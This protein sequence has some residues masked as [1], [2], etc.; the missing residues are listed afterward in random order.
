[1]QFLLKNDSH[2]MCGFFIYY[3]ITMLSQR[4]SRNFCS[5]HL[6]TAGPAVSSDQDAQGSDVTNAQGVPLSSTW[7]TFSLCPCWTPHFTSGPLSL[8]LP[9]CSTVGPLAASSLPPVQRCRFLPQAKPALFLHL[10]AQEEWFFPNAS[11]ASAELV[12]VCHVIPTEVP[13]EGST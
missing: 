6:P 9:S 11:E 4:L 13:T 5:K 1:M 3:R 8:G 2:L 10:S 12:S 7:E